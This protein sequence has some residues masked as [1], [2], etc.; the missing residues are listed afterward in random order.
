MRSIAAVD[1]QGCA[2]D[3]A[4]SVRQQ[5]GDAVGD[6]ADRADSQWMVALDGFELFRGEELFQP[7]SISLS[8]KP[9]AIALTRIP[10]GASST[11]SERESDY[12]GF[13]GRIRGNAGFADEA[14][15]RREQHYMLPDSG[16]RQLFW[17]KP[18]A[19]MAAV[20]TLTRITSSSSA[21]PTMRRGTAR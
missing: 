8:T 18:L 6:I 10:S 14:G 2:G 11:A 7:I 19:S 1:G 12:G 5:E 16:W 20:E 21:E 3:P 17:R 13:A 4:R 15:H 9:V